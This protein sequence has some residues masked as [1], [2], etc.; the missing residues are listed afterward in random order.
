MTSLKQWLSQIVPSLKFSIILFVTVLPRPRQL[1]PHSLTEVTSLHQCHTSFLRKPNS[2]S[3]L[4]YIWQM[5]DPEF[6]VGSLIFMKSK[7]KHFWPCNYLV[8]LQSY[9]WIQFAGHYTSKIRLFGFHNCAKIVYLLSTQTPLMYFEIMSETKDKSGP[10]Q[11]AKLTLNIHNTCFVLVEI[12]YSAIKSF[13]LVSV[14]ILKWRIFWYPLGQQI[15]K[16]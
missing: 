3:N 13:D 7:G 1:R 2:E 11:I 8:F 9:N 10:R 14:Y 4:V 5:A 6:L 12:I 15:L 16:M